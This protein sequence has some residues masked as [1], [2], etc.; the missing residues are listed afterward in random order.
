MTNALPATLLILAA[1]TGSTL[2]RAEPVAR[3]PFYGCFDADPI[4]AEDSLLP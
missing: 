1:L 4:P 3:T 2:V